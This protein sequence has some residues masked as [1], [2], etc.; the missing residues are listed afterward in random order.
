L[1]IGA[2]DVVLLKHQQWFRKHRT[3]AE[4]LHDDLSLR[5]VAAFAPGP[6]T[7]AAITEIRSHIGKTNDALCLVPAPGDRLSMHR[8]VTDLVRQAAPDHQLLAYECLSTLD[9]QRLTTAFPFDE[10]L[11]SRKAHAIRAHQSMLARRE[12]FGGYSNPGSEFYDTIVRRH[13]A[14]V[15]RQLNLDAPFAE[16]F[17]WL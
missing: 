16:R 11:M 14:N 17:G 12:A 2:A 7:K 4:F 10:A 6:I 8:I 13:N 3:P 9:T 1:G 15:A 5:D